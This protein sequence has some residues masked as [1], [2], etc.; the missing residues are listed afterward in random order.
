MND[1]GARRRR[2]F[3]TPR[4]HDTG[5]DFTTAAEGYVRQVIDFYDS[6]AR[7]HRR[8]YRASGVAAI[9][10]ASSLPLL[11]VLDMAG[12]TVIVSGVGCLVAVTTALK[13]FYRWD[14]SWVLLRRTEADLTLA[15][16]AY[17]AAK[18]PGAPPDPRAAH[19]LLHQVLR[20]REEE[21]LRFFR[22]LPSPVGPAPQ[23]HD[24]SLDRPPAAA[25]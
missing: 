8:F 16:T 18:E 19:A 1:S 4:W 11:S 20:I 10:G 13:E 7:W 5:V 17:T 3:S 15:Y 22:N 9:L 6:R 14:T 21:S 23:S 25:G 24:Q 2:T 12:K